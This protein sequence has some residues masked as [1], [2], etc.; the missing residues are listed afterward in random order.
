MR[1]S[2]ALS[3]I[4][5]VAAGVGCT[6]PAAAQT[7]AA[8]TVTTAPKKHRYPPL[9]QREFDNARKFVGGMMAAG[10]VVPVPKD[11][12]GGYTHEQHKRNYRAI[13]LAGQLY[14]L[15]GNPAYANFIRRE[16]LAYAVLYPK[17]GLHPAAKNPQDAG[18]L[19]WQVLNDSVW[20]VYAVQGYEQVRSTFSQVDRERIENNVFRPMA[21]FLSVTQ[22]HNFDRIHNHATWATAAVGMTGYM[23]GDH[24]LVKRALYGSDESGKSGFLRQ[25]DLL[26]SP[27]GYY[28]EG[29]YY[30]RYAML[31][32]MVFAEAIQHNDPSRHIFQYR[33]GVLLKALRTTI[34]L[35]Y[36]GYFFPINDSLKDKSLRTDELYNGVAI[37]YAQTHDPQLLSIAKW[38]G[39]TVL[40]PDGLQVARDLAAGKAQPFIFPSLLLRDGPGG[41]LGALA[42]LR[43]TT[44][45]DGTVLVAK[46]TSQ[47]MGHGHFDK[48]NWLYYDNGHEVVTDYGSARFLNIEAKD[49]G[50]YL[51]ENT[52]WAK[53][54]VAHNTLVVDETSDFGGNVQVADRYAPT[55]L[56]YSANPDLQ[57]STAE[58]DTAYPAQHVKMLRT[59]ALMPVDGLKKPIVIDVMRASGKGR[60][61][62]DLPL[63]Y[64]GHIMKIGF[65]LHSFVAERPV[66]GTHD[67]YQHIWVDATGTPKANQSFVTWLL[68]G[69]FYTYRFIPEAR[70][71]VIL[72]QIGAHDPDFNLRREP[73]LIQR[74]AGVDH[75]DFV[76]VLEPHGKYDGAAETTVRSN[77]QIASIRHIHQNGSD[78]VIVKTLT[79]DRTALAVSYDKDPTKEHRLVVD[80]QTVSWTGFAARLS[81]GHEKN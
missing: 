39:R 9:F 19:F 30:Q 77:S 40:T 7:S 74:V 70:E 45:M 64:A 46:N 16:L 33:N 36:K 41:K 10:I 79:G 38:Q 34:Q 4:L 26:F 35:T 61:S 55:Q 69:R 8:G 76:S 28:V 32:F 27:D 73:M 22:H 66:L 78:L 13:Y 63:H 17:L 51:P 57:I 49:G 24:D 56:Y 12:G 67:G 53:Q 52:S 65:P 71:S 59:L 15:T 5:A 68:G 58:L 25:I 29:P 50:R 2:V 44:G 14:R 72:G 23:L 60:I 81:L 42:I 80:G 6:Q 11:P 48:L 21:H 37:A 54:T 3:I 1:G 75:V 62:F 20:L 31:P 18:K 47:G 43:R